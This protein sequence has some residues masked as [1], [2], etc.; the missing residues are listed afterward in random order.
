MKG[1]FRGAT[2]VAV[3]VSN[4]ALAHSQAA[5]RTVIFEDGFSTS[6][7]PVVSGAWACDAPVA[8]VNGWQLMNIRT[9]FMATNTN[10]AEFAS[11]EARVYSFDNSALGGYAALYHPIH[12][13]ETSWK[14]T[15]VIRVDFAVASV[16]PVPGCFL[17]MDTPVPATC[18]PFLGDD[19]I[20]TTGWQMHTGQELILRDG[21]LS[22][23]PL[24]TG[25]IVPADG[26]KHAIEL[27]SS[28]SGSEL[29]AWPVVS[30]M[31]PA[32][33]LATGQSLGTVKRI[34]FNGPNF[35]NF[36]YSIDRVRLERI[37]SPSEFGTSLPAILIA[38]DFEAASCSLIAPDWGCDEPLAT[39]V[40]R[41]L[42][43]N[44]RPD[45]MGTNTNHLDIGGGVAELWSTDNSATGGYAAFYHPL[46]MQ[47][48]AFRL[49][50]EV[51]VHAATAERPVPSCFVRVEPPAPTDPCPLFPNDASVTLGWQASAGQMLVLLDGSGSPPSAGYT[52]TVG[53]THHVVELISLGGP[54]GGS[55]LRAW[56]AGNPRPVNPMATGLSLGRPKRVMFGGPNFKNFDYSIESVLL[57]A[58]AY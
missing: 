23:F 30:G 25:Y 29:R 44:S 53:G 22:A 27:I 48:S 57:E 54:L 40:G 4:S 20:G 11:G 17:N 12:C 1:F 38:E 58:L 41:W 50:V 2:L 56:P 9:D 45:F 26:S 52:L 31:R 43:A 8:L 34:L 14:L 47:P 33:P 15:T 24:E 10:T 37:P 39:C 6:A 36:D 49:T 5:M 28:P 46:H 13:D 55:E 42:L 35:Q 32:A 19:P 7:G 16:R 21:D 51:V 3:L 18:F